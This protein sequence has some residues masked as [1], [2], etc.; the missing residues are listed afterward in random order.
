MAISKTVE[1]L[2]GKFS[3]VL[4]RIKCPVDEIGRNSVRP[5]TTPRMAALSSSIKSK[6]IPE[7]ERGGL[8]FEAVSRGWRLALA[9]DIILDNDPAMSLHLQHQRI[10]S[11]L[12]P[13]RF[14]VSTD[15]A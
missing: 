9:V 4:A 10:G 15:S 5:S 7:E 13:L 1:M 6:I 2:R 3:Q 11:Y 12:N 14:I 8:L